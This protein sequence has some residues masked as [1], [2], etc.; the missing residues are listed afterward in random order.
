MKRELQNNDTSQNKNNHPIV[1]KTIGVI[2]TIATATITAVIAK[3]T[4]IIDKIN[5]NEVVKW[6]S[7]LKSLIGNPWF[8]IVI[9]VA[10]ICITICICKMLNIKKEQEHNILNAIPTIIKEDKTVSSV[11]VDRNGKKMS[12]SIERN[13]NSNTSEQNKKQNKL[14]HFPTSRNSEVKK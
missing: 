2:G 5:L 7:K 3:I 4:G 12:I 11:N 10:I 14:I 9:I 6:F 13:N 1:T 8:C